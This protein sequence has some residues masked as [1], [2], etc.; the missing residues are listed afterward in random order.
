MSFSKKYTLEAVEEFN[1][2]I[3]AKVYTKV[4]DLNG[5]VYVTPEPVSFKDKLIGEYSPLE[6]GKPWG[7][8]WDCGYMHFKGRVP[9]D[10]V[11]KKVVLMIDVNGEGC[12]LDDEGN[13]IRGITSNSSTFDTEL[14]RP[15]KR[16]LQFIEN[17]C[18]DEE[19]DVW[20][21]VG[22]NDLFGNLKENGVLQQADI[23]ICNDVIRDYFYDYSFLLCLARNLDEGNAKRQQIVEILLKSAAI[24]NLDDNGSVATSRFLL[25]PLFEQGSANDTLNLWAMGHAHMDLAWLWPIRET[26]RKIARTFSTA[27]ELMSRYDD[28]RFGASQPQQFQWIKECYPKLYDRVKQSVN[29]GKLEC[30]G[31]MWVEPDT[32]LSGGEALVRQV[33]YGK[34]FF[35]EEFGKEIDTLWLPDVFGY[36]GALPQILKKSAVPYFMTI[37]LSW[38]KHNEFPHHTFLWEGIDGSEVLAHMPPEGTY[39]SGATPLSLLTAAKKFK[40]KDVCSDALLLFGIGDG[41]G[42]P[43]TEHL[44]FLAREKNMSHLPA[45]KQVFAKE[46]FAHIN[47]NRSDYKRWVGELYL[48]CHQGTY[49]TQANTKKYNRLLETM[50]RDCEFVS[51]MACKYGEYTYPKQQLETIWKEVLLYQFHDILPGSSIKRVYDEAIERYKVLEQEVQSLIDTA[52]KIVSESASI[53]QSH[54]LIINTQG[55]ERSYSDLLSVPPYSFKV[56]GNDEC[57]PLSKAEARTIHCIENDLVTVS[58]DDVGNISSIYDKETKREVINT[59]IDTDNLVVYEDFGDCWDMHFTYAEKSPLVKTLKSS[60]VL[61]NKTGVEFVYAIG[62]STI[63]EQISLSE[64]SKLIDFKLD[65]DWNETNRMLRAKYPVAIQTTQANCNIQFGY[66]SRP[67]HQNTSWDYAR[68]EVCA[69]KWV[70][71]SEKGYG[72]ALINNS[73]YGFKVWDNVLDINL[74]RSPMY[75]GKDA[76]KGKHTINYQLL[77]HDG[78]LSKVNAQA[79]LFNSTPITVTQASDGS[80]MEKSFISIS[81]KNIIVEAVKQAEYSEDIVMRVYESE[82]RY[83]TAIIAV[84]GMT[85]ASITNMLEVAESSL[86]VTNNSVEL[87]FKPFEIHT[88]VLKS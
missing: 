33:L 3:K 25:K 14:G 54:R 40:D 46:F 81:H 17:S 43:S 60:R 38:S 31:A 12:L 34:K 32:N 56:V 51:V 30:Q 68:F 39:N 26:K 42:G 69:H 58:I 15:V 77:I 73:K 66:I 79:Y 19:V 75:P 82:G 74:L 27:L 11:G 1:K 41:G 64:Y 9:N 62:N 88:L 63:I 86:P 70:D 35:K 2:M 10:V 36:S 65:V 59:K 37:K 20:L 47:E 61:E 76:D 5:E 85:T 23:A 67:T 45:T 21:E 24:C 13:P 28:Y 83:T 80:I 50:L 52:A 53:D 29:D 55:A 49:T 72:V 8:L 22:C 16:V 18:G 7:K 78:N 4:A 48:E 84:D 44:E 87:V 71:M 6:V 57:M